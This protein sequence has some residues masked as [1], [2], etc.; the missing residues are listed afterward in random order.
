[1]DFRIDI[2]K[3]C[4][5]D[6][7]TTKDHCIPWFILAC[8]SK[9]EKEDALVSENRLERLAK[10]CLTEWENIDH[11]YKSLLTKNDLHDKMFSGVYP[12]AMERIYKQLRLLKHGK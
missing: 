7:E 8:Y 12:R 3:E 10:M 9:Y 6:V 4:M 11:E 5:D 1:M 2:D